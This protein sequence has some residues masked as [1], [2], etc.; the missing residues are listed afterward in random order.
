[1]WVDDDLRSSWNPSDEEAAAWLEAEHHNVVAAIEYDARRGTGR[2][3]WALINLI[4]GLLF[5]RHDVSGLLVA[6]DAALAAAK[7]HG[8]PRAEGA[9]CLERGWLR[10]RG[11]QSDGATQDFARART[12]FHEVGARRPEASALRAL[13]ASHVDTGRPDDARRYAEAALAIYRAESDAGGRA[14]TLNNLAVIADRAADFTAAAVY[15]EES[16][17]LHRET[18]RRSSVALGLAN[19]AHNYLVRGAIT[20]A[21][22]WAEEA[23]AIAREIGDGLSESA[24]LANGADAHEQ[25]G[26]LDEAHRWAQAGLARAREIGYPFAE[27]AALNALATTS[28]RLG[29][30]DARAHRSRALRRARQADNLGIEAEVLVGAARDA[31]QDAMDTTPHADHAFRVAHDSAQR[32]LDSGLAAGI[33]YVQA[34]ALGLLAACDLGLGKVTDA[35]TDAHQAV[36]M[37]VASGARLAEATARCVLAQALFRDADPAAARHEL[38]AARDLLDELAVP[39]A[40]PVRRVL[41][42]AAVSSLP[43]FA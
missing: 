7:R 32:A 27:A 36:E 9:M 8:D 29:H 17:A 40:A 13:S 12:L 15:M 19:L 4:S 2:D 22:T 1:V 10:L 25:N 38:R 11:G 28:R 14:A 30:A 23:V 43:L 35:L 20:R 42:A 18:G 39:D 33:L 31:Y 34:E 26:S 5:R 16:L 24:G 3:A 37:H 21:I 6:T 41:D